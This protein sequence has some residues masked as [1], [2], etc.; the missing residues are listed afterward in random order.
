M[1]A[2]T[3]RAGGASST[4]Q[5]DDERWARAKRGSLRLSLDHALE[6]SGHA[7]ITWLFMYC[8]RWFS[9]LTEVHSAP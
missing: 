5:S 6:G 9:L 3:D 7:L 8:Y 4:E 1:A 2:L